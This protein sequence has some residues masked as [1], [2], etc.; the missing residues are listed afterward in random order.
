MTLKHYCRL[1]T[2]NCEFTGAYAVSASY[3]QV[4]VY[5]VIFARFLYGHAQSRNTTG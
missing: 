5:N 4:K 1:K 2:A 3:G